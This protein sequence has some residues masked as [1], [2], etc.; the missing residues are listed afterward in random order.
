[1]FNSLKNVL[2]RAFMVGQFAFY[3]NFQIYSI[4]HKKTV[5]GFPA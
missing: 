5:F 3:D 2:L 4:K 1:M